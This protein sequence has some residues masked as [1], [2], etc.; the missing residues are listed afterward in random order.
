MLNKDILNEDLDENG[1]D[2]DWDEE[3]VTALQ[4]IGMLPPSSL[5]HRRPKKH[6]VFVE[7]DAAG[8]RAS[9]LVEELQL[10]Q[11]CSRRIFTSQTH[12][13][14]HFNPNFGDRY[15]FRLDK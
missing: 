2:S 11:D 7:N 15:C 3:D 13:A 5:R 6:I 1:L 14:F 12:E 8:K 9:E 10:I 4:N